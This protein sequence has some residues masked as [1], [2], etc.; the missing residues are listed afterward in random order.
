MSVLQD[1][2]S[3]LIQ[4][5]RVDKLTLVLIVVHLLYSVWVTLNTA[6]WCGRTLAYRFGR[7]FA[8][9]GYHRRN[10]SIDGQYVDGLSLTHG[11]SGSRQHIWTFASGLFTESHYSRN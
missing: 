6:E 3:Q 4:G 10:H 2:T 1:L 7:N 9:L 8:F 5:G 11:A